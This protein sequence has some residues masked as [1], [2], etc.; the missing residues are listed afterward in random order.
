LK[1]VELQPRYQKKAG[2][3]GTG[4]LS[5]IDLVFFDWRAYLA[6]AS[7]VIM[8]SSNL[9]S[10]ANAHSSAQLL[11]LP[12]SD[13]SSSLLEQPNSITSATADEARNSLRNLNVFISSILPNGLV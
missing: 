7:Q 8:H 2:P 12:V 11:P 10:G 6:Q 13:D 3:F 1:L 9:W 5:R 4:F